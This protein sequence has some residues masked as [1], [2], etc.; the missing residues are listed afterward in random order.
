MVSSC[1]AGHE[2]GAADSD[3]GRLSSKVSPQGRQRYS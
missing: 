1:P 3:I 2:A